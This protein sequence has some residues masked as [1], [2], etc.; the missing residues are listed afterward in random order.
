M[1]AAPG[2]F[3]DTYELHRLPIPM[4]LD[5]YEALR[6]KCKEVFD[7][8]WDSNVLWLT[9][10]LGNIYKCNLALYTIK[11][12]ILNDVLV[13]LYSAQGTHVLHKCFKLDRD[14][15]LTHAAIQEL[16]SAMESYTGG[17]FRCVYCG[18]IDRRFGEG[19]GYAPNSE[20]C[21]TCFAKPEI[22]DRIQQ[23]FHE[24]SR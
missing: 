9:D 10:I 12:Q 19:T 3:I 1:Q 14:N 2:I 11:G 22:K 5:E 18:S 16:R 7:F 4:L 20:V 24:A 6:K 15:R 13:T 17:N 21:A 23:Q 8:R